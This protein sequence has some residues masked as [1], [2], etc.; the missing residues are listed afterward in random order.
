[1][2][3]YK[4]NLRKKIKNRVQFKISLKLGRQWIILEINIFHSKSEKQNDLKKLQ[5][6]GTQ[7]LLDRSDN[8]YSQEWIKILSIQLMKHQFELSSQYKSTQEFSQL[9]ITEMINFILKIDMILFQTIFV[10][11][12]KNKT[13]TKFLENVINIV[14][15]N[16]CMS[17]KQSNQNKRKNL[18]S[19]KSF[20]SSIGHRAIKHWQLYKEGYEQFSHVHGFFQR[21]ILQEGDSRMSIRRDCQPSSLIFKMGQ[22]FCMLQLS[23]LRQMKD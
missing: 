6:L 23:Y 3:R 19:P 21:Q 11:T 1:M 13:N 8:L 12:K 18:S 17:L 10:Q 22:T 9:K 4:I 15:E 20:W 14:I 7:I 5:L 16:N 2:K